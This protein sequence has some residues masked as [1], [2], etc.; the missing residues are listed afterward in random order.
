MQ[1]RYLQN[2]TIMSVIRLGTRGSPL[3]LRQTEL[4]I[5]HLKKALPDTDFEIV[6]ISTTGDNKQ[7]WSLEQ[8]GGVGLFTKELENALLENRVDVAIHSAK[9]MPSLD[10][11]GLRILGYLPREDVSDVLVVKKG[12]KKPVFIATSS[13]RRRAQAKPSYPNAVWSEIRGN[14]DTRLKKVASGSVDATYL[15][16]AGLNRLGIKEWPGVEFNPINLEEMVPAGG[17]GAI[18]LQCRVGDLDEV[19]Q[20]FDQ[21]TNH[22]VKIERSFLAKLGIGCH[23]AFAVHYSEKKLLIYHESM[24]EPKAFKFEAESDDDINKSID[25]IVETLEL[26]I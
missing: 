7:G 17:Q 23:T 6:K 19:S 25:E 2:A 21:A 20:D 4:A 26:K 10:P 24:A 14:V 5:E 13:P 16:A 12:C 8:Q 22:A 18:A 11:K 9:D 1:L 3:A 15:A